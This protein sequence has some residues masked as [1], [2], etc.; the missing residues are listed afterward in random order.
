MANPFYIAQSALPTD[1]MR[2]MVAQLKMNPAQF[3]ASRF[4]IPQ[5]LNDPYA[6]QQ[7][8]LA[9]GQITQEQINRAYQMARSL[10]F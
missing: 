10:G 1:N 2:Q 8:L 4:H 6:I 3:L 5:N 9:T 7:H